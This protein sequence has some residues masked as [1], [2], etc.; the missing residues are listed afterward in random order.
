MMESKEKR[1]IEK[2]RLPRTAKKLNVKRMAAE[3][4]EL[5]L[6]IEDGEEVYFGL[7]CLT[8]LATI[9]QLYCGGQFYWWSKPEYAEKTFDLSQ[10]TDKLYHI[11]LHRVHLAMNGVQT[12]NVVVIGI[13]CTGSCKSSFHTIMNTTAP[14]EEVCLHIKINWSRYSSPSLIGPPL[15]QWPLKRDGLI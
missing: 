6:E 12:H 3:M 13:D 7:W 2:P 4:G 1:T 15:L 9:F 5:G 11:M 8:P 10:V 14:G